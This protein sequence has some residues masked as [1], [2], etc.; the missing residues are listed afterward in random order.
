MNPNPDPVV[1]DRALARANEIRS[2][3]AAWRQRVAAADGRDGRR[4]VATIL[5]DEQRPSELDTLEV[6]ELLCWVRRIQTR[7]AGMLLARARVRENRQI[8]ELTVRQR[9]KIAALLEPWE[10]TP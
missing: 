2:T 7:T 9:H 3:R 10:V 6:A 1:R 4:L 5:R 8:R